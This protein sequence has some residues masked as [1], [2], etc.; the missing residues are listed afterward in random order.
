MPAAAETPSGFRN[1][2][3]YLL[4]PD[5]DQMLSF[6]AASFGAETTTR[7]VAPNGIHSSF[8]LGDSTLMMGGPV[9]GRRAMLHLYVDGLEEA[10][11]RALDAGGVARYPITLA[12]YGERFA[13][14]DDPAGN[15]WIVAERATSAL[16]HHDMGTVTPYLN[17]NGAAA[18][19]EFLKTGLGAEQIERHDHPPRGVAHCKMR[20]GRSILELGDPEDNA[21]AFSV[22]FYLYVASVDATYEQAL[23]AGAVSLQPPASQHYGDY[24]AAFTDPAGNQWYVAE[25]RL[26][27]VSRP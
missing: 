19:I 18:L 27:T 6:Y 11:Q 15:A 13:V 4:V 10:V 24:V 12:P 22:M 3:P 1:L 23:K 2:T 8:K 17:P 21:A 25:H 16:R 7:D 9:T 20:L 14:V 5:V 26:L